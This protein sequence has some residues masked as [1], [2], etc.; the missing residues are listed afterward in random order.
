M[1]NGSAVGRT[2]PTFANALRGYRIALTSGDTAG[3]DAV[4]AWLGGQP[5]V[6][7][8]ARR[9]AGIRGGLDHF[10]ALSFLQGLLVVLRDCGYRAAA[11]PR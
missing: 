6:S 11:R 10:G 1:P 4:L 9:H 7:A 8:A 5:H 2:A 3:A